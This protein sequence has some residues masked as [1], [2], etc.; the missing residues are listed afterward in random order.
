MP[1]GVSSAETLESIFEIPG[2]TFFYWGFTLPKRR[3]SDFV[4]YFGLGEGKKIVPVK[5]VIGGKEYNAKIDLI[6]I[7]S[8]KYP[9]R[10]VMRLFYEGEQETLKA[11]RKLFMY[12]YASTID[13]S[14]SNLKEL[15]ELIHLGGNR[16]RVK[17]VAKQKTDFDPMFRKLEDK[18]LFDYWKDSKK[19]KEAS[20]FI[21]A[22]K[23]WLNASDLKKYGDRINVIYVLYHT[24]NK[25]LYVGKA[26]RLGERVKPGEGGGRGIADGWDKFMFFVLNPDYNAFVKQIEAFLIQTF[27]SI[28]ENDLKNVRISPLITGWIKLMNKQLIS[29]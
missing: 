5:L 29:D 28:M 20:F 21:E 4:R 16:F 14:R 25:Q 8:P 9:N 22:S 15:M 13:K 3:Y 19:G 7:S 11:M 27:A 26:D 1:G 17:P 2:Y 24:K 18:N 6:R 10:D 12:S 23:K